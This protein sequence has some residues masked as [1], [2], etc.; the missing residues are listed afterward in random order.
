MREF[1]SAFYGTGTAFEVGTTVLKVNFE[2]LAITVS[3][4]TL[5]T[6]LFLLKTF[7]QAAR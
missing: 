1:T 6:T 4:D 7:A 5:N 2:T 3:K